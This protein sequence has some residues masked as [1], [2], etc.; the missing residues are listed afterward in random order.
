MK[1][2][3][4]MMATG[5]GLGLAPIAS[6]TAGA[7]PGVILAWVLHP[8][9][10]VWQAAAALALCA[11]SIPICEVAERHFVTKDDR[12][13]VADEY[14]TFPV[15]LIGIPWT[16]HAWFLGIAFVVSRIMDIIKP[17]PARGLQDL[18]GGL[19]IT[20]DDVIANVYALAVNWGLWLAVAKVFG[21]S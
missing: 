7:L 3:V 13:I 8:L 14:L 16:E 9:A 21:L 2:M 20:V 10:A 11:L 12:R 19:G 18:H 15:C 6:G 5:F 17:P 1:K 4:V